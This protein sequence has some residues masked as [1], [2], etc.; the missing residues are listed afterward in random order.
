[1]DVVHRDPGALVIAHGNLTFRAYAD[2]I[3]SAHAGRKDLKLLA[4]LGDLEDAAVVRGE[5]TPPAAAW[6][7]R[8]A[9]GE[10]KVPL[11]IGLQIERELVEPWRDLHVVV[12]VLVEV[13]L[14]VAV[15]VV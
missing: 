6:I 3:R 10:V 13:R 15:D 8:A 5:G 1:M 7:H 11:R 12:E 4:I 2:A 9:L 14:A